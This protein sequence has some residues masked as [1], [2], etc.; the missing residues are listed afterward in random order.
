M[1]VVRNTAF[2][3]VSDGKEFKLWVPPRRQVHHRPGDRRQLSAGQAAWRT[4]GR[5]ISTKPC[6]CP[7]SVR[8]PS[9]NC[10]IA[11]LENGYETVLDPRKHR[12]EQPDY[13]LAVIRQGPKAGICGGGSSSAEPTCCPTSKGF[14]TAG[15]RRDGR[16]LYRITKILVASRSHPRLRSNDRAR[17]TTSLST[18][19]NWI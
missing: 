14:T 4:C 9:S 19:S 10:E 8:M 11:V 15:K 5:S 6:C 12:V 1:P 2:D 18:Y 13:E 7:R 16:Y 17:I 3:M